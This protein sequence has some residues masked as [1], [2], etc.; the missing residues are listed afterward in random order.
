MSALSKFSPRKKR[1]LTVLNL[2]I[3]SSLNSLLDV[4]VIGVCVLFLAQI[5]DEHVISLN[6][7]LNFY[8]LSFAFITIFYVGTNVQIS[9]LFGAKLFAQIPKVTSTFLIGGTIV[10]LPIVAL[11][12][13]AG[14][15][16]FP[17]LHISPDALSMANQFTKSLMIAFPAVM[18]KNVIIAAFAAIGNTILPFVV[19]LVSSVIMIFATYFLLFGAPSLHIPELGVSGAKYV[20]LIVPY[21]ETA[22]FFWILTRQK[23]LFSGF[24]FEKS[25]L[26]KGVKIGMPTGIERFFM[27]FA[28]VLASKFYANYGDLALGGTQIGARIETFSFVLAFGFMTAAMVLMGQCIGAGKISLAK[29]YIRMILTLTAYIMGI[30]GAILVIFG[31]YF[32]NFFATDPEIINS[33]RTY[34]IAVGLSQIPLIFI[35]V[36]DGALRGAG[37]SKTALYINAISLWLLRMLPMA[38]MSAF[39]VPLYWLYAVIC[40]ETFIRAW[41]FFRAYKFG[42]WEKVPRTL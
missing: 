39:L 34:L 6:V 12:I 5:D 19:R 25:A 41:L 13:I 4:L 14:R 30:T 16:Y 20:F 35:F 8:V 10:S 29:I 2:A 27:L 26:K 21:V 37:L 28:I 38:V 36:L 24:A 32:S 42:A 15:F 3:P 31:G 1:L 9:R 7:A 23:T 40:V 33:S 17:W 18:A 11:F 22:V